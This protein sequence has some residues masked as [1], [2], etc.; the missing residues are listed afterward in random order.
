MVMMSLA[1]KVSE[2]TR[3][4]FKKSKP[5]ELSAEASVA[6]KSFKL[7][8]ASPRSSVPAA[9]IR[10]G[11]PY[12]IAPTLTP[13]INARSDDLDTKAVVSQVSMFT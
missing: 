6:M 1:A 3:K 10:Y 13:G 8:S 11:Y 12:S 5:S 7:Q 2:K 9:S 4:D